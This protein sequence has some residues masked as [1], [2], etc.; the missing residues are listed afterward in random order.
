MTPVENLN[1]M[2]ALPEMVL[3][4]LAIFALLLGVASKEEN[5]KRVLKF[6]IFSLLVAAVLIFKQS[7]KSEVIFG[8]MFVTDSFST[9]MKILAIL[10]SV[11][12]LLISTK[13]VERE[14]INHI[15]YPV[16]ILFSTIGMSLMISSNSIIT[17]YMG[18]ELQS[19]PLYVLAAIKRDSIKSTEVGLKYFILG[20][21]SSGLLLYGASMIYGFT[22][23]M[24]F[25]E[26]GVSF[27]HNSAVGSI[28]VITGMVLMIT[29]L[30]FKVSAVPFHMWAPDVYE[31]APSSVVAFFAIAPK[32]AAMALITRVLIMPFGD[33]VAMWRQIIIVLSVGSMAWGAIAAIK[34]TNIKRMLAYSAI[35]HMGYA[36]IGLAVATKIGLKSLVIYITVYAVMS[37]GSF[38]IVMMMKKKNKEVENIKDL[39]GL[40]KQQPLLALGMAIIMFSM[41]GIPPFAGFFSKLF[42]FQAAISSGFYILA[43]IGLF[44]SVIAAYYYLRVVKVM[45]FEDVNSGIDKSDDFWSNLILLGTSAAMVLFIFIPTPL[46]HAAG[47]AVQALIK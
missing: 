13:Y 32:I 18:L 39:A 42:I 46:L 35:G 12:A 2:A 29:G 28:G 41:A 22:G 10:G 30:A 36:L 34:Q 11:V 45:Y 6:S 33:M 17:L 44:L 38:C 14:K 4:L 23:A 26:I 9:Y 40:G 43:I 5:Y 16:L 24:G 3:S 15:D 27:S 8:G 47:F 20:A 25:E 21:L 7:D 1:V 19:L 37:A 31:G